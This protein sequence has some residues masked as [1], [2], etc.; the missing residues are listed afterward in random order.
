MDIF[1]EGGTPYPGDTRL[2]TEVKMLLAL[3]GGGG[4]GP[5]GG[6]SSV[7]SGDGDQMVFGD[8]DQVIFGAGT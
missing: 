2:V 4:M 6:P 1:G 3:V 8:G 5:M 7:V